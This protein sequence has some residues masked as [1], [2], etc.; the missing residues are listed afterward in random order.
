GRRGASLH[1]FLSSATGR[2]PELFHN[3]NPLRGQPVMEGGSACFVAGA[4]PSGSS[5]P[6]SAWLL[7]CRR[8]S[9]A[10]WRRRHLLLIAVALTEPSFER[11]DTLRQAPDGLLEIPERGKVRQDRTDALVDRVLPLLERRSEPFAFLALHLLFSHGFFPLLAVHELPE[12]PIPQL[13]KDAF[14]AMS[15]ERLQRRQGDRPGASP[16]LLR[17]DEGERHIRLVFLRCIVDDLDVL[18][19][20]NHLRNLKERDVAAAL[21]IVELAVRV[22]LDDSPL[23]RRRFALDRLFLVAVHRLPPAL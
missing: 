4:P 13:R 19:G 3:A 7:R 18:A 16:E 11:L 10:G 14:A 8:R 17:D 22:P 21:R 15:D 5:P 9:A 12:G 6:T 1:T 23:G 2:Q 20:P